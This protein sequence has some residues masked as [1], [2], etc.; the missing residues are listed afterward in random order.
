MSSDGYMLDR[1]DLIITGDIFTCIQETKEYN[2]MI[3]LYTTDENDNLE[4]EDDEQF[5]NAYEKFLTLVNCYERNGVVDEDDHD[6][7][8]L[9]QEEI[10]S[11]CDMLRDGDYIFMIED[12]EK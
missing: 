6:I 10:S 1:S 9:T 2:S 4:N 8:M 3:L 5:D 12:S 7:L 11:F